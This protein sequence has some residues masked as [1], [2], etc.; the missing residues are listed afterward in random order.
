MS[1]DRTTQSNPTPPTDP[2]NLEEQNVHPEAGDVVDE[3]DA[4]LRQSS[5]LNP[6][7]SEKS[8]ESPEEA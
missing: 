4:E 2:N 3:T 8:L 6:R 1:G 7:V 5:P